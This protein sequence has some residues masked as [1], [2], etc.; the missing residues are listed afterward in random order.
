[1]NLVTEIKYNKK[2][3]ATVT[4]MAKKNKGTIKIGNKSHKLLGIFHNQ[5]KNS[6]VK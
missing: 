4:V 3:I 1:M 5:N 2:C 6:L